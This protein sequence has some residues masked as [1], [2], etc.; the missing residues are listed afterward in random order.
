MANPLPFS[1]CWLSA[2]PGVHTNEFYYRIVTYCMG[3]AIATIANSI[4]GRNK[5]AKRAM[6]PLKFK[7]SP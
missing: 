4:G 5:G 7:A 3:I 1:Y 6:A 2:C